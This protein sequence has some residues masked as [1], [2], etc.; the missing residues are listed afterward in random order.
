V[1]SPTPVDLTFLLNAFKNNT[2]G[3]AHAVGVSADGLL[4]ASTSGLPRDRADQL[5][6]VASGLSSLLRTA[7]NLLCAGQV[8]SN[9]TEVDS[10][11]LF[12]MA[13]STGASLFVLATR[14]A[15]IGHVAHEMADL[16]NRVGAALTPTARDSIFTSTAVGGPA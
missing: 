2:P 12:S 10:G 7:A 3:V 8:S 14:E 1:S 11:F 6:A 13:V 4:I 9:V 16:I 5:A 15:D